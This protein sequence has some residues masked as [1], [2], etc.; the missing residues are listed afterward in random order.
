MEKR[1]HLLRGSNPQPCAPQ[2]QLGAALGKQRFLLCSSGLSSSLVQWLS[3]RVAQRPSGGS[4]LL[5]GSYPTSILC[6]E[7]IQTTA[8][9]S[10]GFSTLLVCPLHE[11][12]SLSLK[13][14]GR[15]G[16]LVVSILA[17]YSDNP[18]SNP[19]G[20]FNVL[21]EKTKINEKRPGLAHLLKVL[22]T[23]SEGQYF[24]GLIE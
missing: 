18:S 1:Q 5:A 12:F 9:H 23:T 16:G 24:L 15:G 17:Y 13:N 7:L 2:V 8:P 4:L 22:K 21:Y 3:G 14:K 6:L 11:I 19:A 10:L 20:Y